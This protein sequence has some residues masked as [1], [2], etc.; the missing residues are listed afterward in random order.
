MVHEQRMSEEQKQQLEGARQ[1]LSQA[2]A[3]QADVAAVLSELKEPRI[4][5]YG[6]NDIGTRF[7]IDTSS[8]FL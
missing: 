4:W 5:L 1:A 2:L 7:F 3:H 6:H 8:M